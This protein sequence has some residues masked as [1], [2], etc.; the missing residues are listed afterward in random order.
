MFFI[1]CFF[2][3][4]EGDVD[5]IQGGRWHGNENAKVQQKTNSGWIR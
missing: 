2:C 3:L 4:I 5:K 1:D